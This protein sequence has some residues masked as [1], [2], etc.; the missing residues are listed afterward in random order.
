MGRQ[1]LAFAGAAR[2]LVTGW[3]WPFVALA[4]GAAPLALG[5]TLGTPFHQAATA[6]L[7][8]PLFWACVRDDR[9]GRAVALVVLVIGTHSALAILLSAVDPDR[10]ARV[11]P[12]SEAYW[13]Q[14]WHWVRTG[15]DPE[16]VLFTW[17]P[18]H[19][20]LLF[21]VALCAYT[22]LGLLPFIYGIG[23]VDLMN[24]Y[25][26]RLMVASEQ[27]ALA[28]AAG[29]HPWSVLRGL[30]YT[31]LVYEVASLSLERLSGVKLSTVRRRR[32][33]WAAALGFCVADGVVKFGTLGLVREVLFTNLPPETL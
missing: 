26:G 13:Q 22:S 25:V 24:F 11:L 1:L 23:Q 33:R 21:G 9:Q 17:L 8:A 5:Y 18:T 32:L 14:T 10:A 16:Y 19:L 4:A 20:L 30:G 29:W 6:L 28:L 15:D 12:G 31:F 7:L 2:P 27:P 3:R